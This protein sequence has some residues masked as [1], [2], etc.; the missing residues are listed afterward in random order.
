MATEDKVTSGLG[1]E[2]DDL[3]NDKKILAPSAENLLDESHMKKVDD[4]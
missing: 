4:F 1:R 2:V 3:N